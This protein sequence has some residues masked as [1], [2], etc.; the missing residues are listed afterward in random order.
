MRSHQATRR[1]SKAAGPLAAGDRVRAAAAEL[2]DVIDPLRSQ[3]GAAFTAL[4]DGLDRF[5]DEV[6]R[7]AVPAADRAL[8]TRKQ[9][10]KRLGIG[11][12]T[13]DLHVRAG[14]LPPVTIPSAQG[15]APLKR[16]APETLDRFVSQHS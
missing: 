11:L 2:H 12:N 8:L 14:R 16:W 6:A 1:H 4:L 15:T 13:F 10:A 9:A 5:A 3:L 7:A